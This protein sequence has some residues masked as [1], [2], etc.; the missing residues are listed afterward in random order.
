MFFLFRLISVFPCFTVFVFVFEFLHVLVLFPPVTG[1]QFGITALDLRTFN[2][3]HLRIQDF[4]VKEQNEQEYAIYIYIYQ[5]IRCSCFSLV[6]GTSHNA[7]YGVCP[8][9]FEPFAF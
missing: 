7:S 9:L 1:E 2:V 5:Y 6:I 3:F 4:E 8:S